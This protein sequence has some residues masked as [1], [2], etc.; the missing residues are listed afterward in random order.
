M[1]LIEQ[2][3]GYEKAKR[4]LKL[5]EEHSMFQCCTAIT[6]DMI[7]DAI[8]EYRREHNI[9]E[10]GDYVLRNDGFPSVIKITSVNKGV[11]ECIRH[12]DG[13]PRWSLFMFNEI[14]HATEEEI[15]AGHREVTA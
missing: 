14:R 8:L 6:A 7:R 10:A 4:E 13:E 11:V 12:I 1:D 9:F 15:K 3:G 5:K 2:L